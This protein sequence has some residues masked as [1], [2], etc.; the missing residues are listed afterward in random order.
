M[1]RQGLIGVCIVLILCSG[2]GSRRLLPEY[3]GMYA[4]DRGKLIPLKDLDSVVEF[5]GECQFILFDKA[6]QMGVGEMDLIKIDYMPKRQKES[7]DGWDSWLQNLDAYTA[8]MEEAISRV[9]SRGWQIP[10]GV[11]PVKNQREMVRIVP[12]KRLDPGYFQLGTFGR[13]IVGKQKILG[14]HKTAMS[15]AAK[16][17]TW[18]DALANAQAILIFQ[19]DDKDAR[20]IMHEIPFQ[21]VARV[22]RTAMKKGDYDEARQAAVEAMKAESLKKEMTDLLT[23]IPRVTVAPEKQKTKLVVFPTDKR[24]R[25]LYDNGVG[26]DYN[27][28]T[29]QITE[30]TNFHSFERP[31]HNADF[32]AVIGKTGG[33]DIEVAFL[34]RKEILKLASFGLLTSSNI[35]TFSISPSAK[36]AAGLGE[37]T[38]KKLGTFGLNV[39][40]STPVKSQFVMEGGKTY[41]GVVVW[42]L[43]KKTCLS[44]LPTGNYPL[45]AFTFLSDEQIAGFN[46]DGKLHTW[47]ISS[48]APVQEVTLSPGFIVTYPIASSADGKQVFVSSG[49]SIASINV[50]SGEVKTLVPPQ[51]ASFGCFSMNGDG[52]LFAFVLG[53]NVVHIWNAAKGAEV[54]AIK[55]TK[56]EINDLALSPNGELLATCLSSE[57]GLWDM[58]KLAK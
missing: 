30:K 41:D 17:G 6:V 11:Q 9:P 12:Q 46:K 1:K 38:Q 45:T 16:N 31:I 47:N 49:N 35:Q 2:C 18:E 10:C 36:F 13:F 34:D 27:I 25:I 7:A 24:L 56:G 58:T 37:W 39:P 15:S 44:F 26:V 40:D 57:I 4:L 43:S 22:A 53:D 55:E 54:M 32:S 21:Q 42:D 48:P 50:Q 8:R 33:T 29:L 23:S 51:G 5:T 52:T 20:A 14:D 28:E 3:Y 19:S